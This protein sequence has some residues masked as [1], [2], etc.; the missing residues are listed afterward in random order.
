MSTNPRRSVTT[1]PDWENPAITGRNRLAPRAD[2]LPYPDAAAALLG[3][4]AAT[5]WF[6][7]LNGV[8]RFHFD[9]SPAEAPADFMRPD[10]DISNWD[11]IPVPR[12]W[13]T[14]GYG[15]PHYTNVQYPFPVD[16]PRVPTDNPT[17]SYRRDFTVPAAWNGSRIHLRFEGVDSAFTVWVNGR[18]AGF[19]KSS[20]TP[21]EFDITSLVTSGINTLAVRVMQWSDG[22]YMEDQDMW[23]L[24]G[25][26]RDVYLI[27][28]PA[29]HLSDFSVLTT[30]DADYADAELKL[31]AVVRNAGRR[32][33]GA[34][35]I[36]AE[37]RDAA[38]KVVARGAAPR[39]LKPPAGREV[40]VEWTLAVAR[41]DKWTA[42]TPALYTLLLT[43]KDAGGAALEVVP[44]QVGFRVVEIKDGIFCVNGAPVKIKGV[45][46]HEH[47]PDLG[48]AIPVEAMIRDLVL[49]KRHNINAVRTSHYPDD[50]RWYDLCDRFGIYIVDECDLET[51]GFIHVADEKNWG[52]E[53]DRGPALGGG[54]RGSHGAHGR[55]RQEPC[56]RRHVVARQ[57]RAP[58]ERC[59]AA[60]LAARAA[61]PHG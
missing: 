60:E 8:W 33:C 12:S 3:D 10:A 9:A 57:R 61:T 55:A 34:L 15:R 51:H 54:L 38:G 56:L 29:V 2:F 37:L 44:A 22:T 28:Q 18:E 13:Q 36:E 19:S 46:R 5:P 42:E 17:G 1:L 4:R 39:A 14:C 52:G 49:M 26:F 45:N 27:A 32:A 31:R 23:W 11:S 58:P 25:I 7:L 43:L 53:S 59:L 47:D 35:R 50:P 20:R 30:F 21:A 24:S 40:A 41:P 48:R 16:P 6:Q